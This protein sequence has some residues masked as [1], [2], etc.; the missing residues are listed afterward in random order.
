[1]T[2]LW[3]EERGESI[4]KKK[5]PQKHSVRKR[6]KNIAIEEYYINRCVNVLSGNFSVKTRTIRTWFGQRN[7]PYRFHFP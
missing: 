6:E 1:M 3:Y 7:D 4:K 5:N 2:L